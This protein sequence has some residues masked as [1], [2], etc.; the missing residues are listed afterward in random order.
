MNDDEVRKLAEPHLKRVLHLVHNMQ[1]VWKGCKERDV[2]DAA[3]TGLENAV[4]T[5]NRSKNA[6]FR[7]WADS[8]IRW[9]IADFAKARK[10]QGREQDRDRFTTKI[11][12]PP[13]GVSMNDLCKNKNCKHPFYMHHPSFR[14]GCMYWDIRLGGSG[15]CQCTGF[16]DHTP[17][18][19]WEE[20]DS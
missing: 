4:R 15:W 7:K 9:A 5:Y 8:K 18:C 19:Q 17:A 10:K 3:F 6:S 14:M 12:Q 16:C 20:G 13:K 2:F 1:A 11:Y